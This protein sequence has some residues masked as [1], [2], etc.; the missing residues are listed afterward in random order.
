[1][2]F[3]GVF[4]GPTQNKS[5]SFGKELQTEPTPPAHEGLNV[6]SA[7]DDRELEQ[8][9]AVASQASL[10]I[11]TIAICDFN[12]SHATVCPTGDSL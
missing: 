1:M 5:K 6:V 12:N 11:N 9:R 3:Q 10:Y 7:S 8:T 4:F 2:S